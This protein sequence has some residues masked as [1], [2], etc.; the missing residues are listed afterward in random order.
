N[1]S[2]H[3]GSTPLNYVLAPGQRVDSTIPNN[4]FYHFNGTSMA[5]PYVAGIA[6][7]ILSANPTLTPDQLK[8]IILQTTTPLPQT[9]IS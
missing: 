5:A 3:A 8:K 6:A 1:I 7:L 9:K 4:G 2:N